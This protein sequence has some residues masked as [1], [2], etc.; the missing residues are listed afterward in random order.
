LYA[1]LREWDLAKADYLSIIK[2]YPSKTAE[3][4]KLI[5]GVEVG[6]ENALDHYWESKIKK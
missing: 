3:I 1:C 2:Y 5:N 4:T 6:A